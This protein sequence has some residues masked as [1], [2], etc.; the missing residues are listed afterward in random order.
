MHTTT[1]LG[2]GGNQSSALE[3]SRVKCDIC[4][5]C[6]L[7]ENNTSLGEKN[8]SRVVWECGISIISLVVSYFVVG[9]THVNC[10]F[11]LVCELVQTTT[12]LG[13]KAPETPECNGTDKTIVSLV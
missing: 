4:L 2:E 9:L 1:S 3:L 13:D 10:V 6:E 8:D 7:V 11:S 5:M 12:S